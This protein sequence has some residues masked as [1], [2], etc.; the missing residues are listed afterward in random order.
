MINKKHGSWY[1]L[2]DQLNKF[3]GPAEKYFDGSWYWDVL[4]MDHRLYGYSIYNDDHLIY[5]YVNHKPLNHF[6]KGA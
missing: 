6:K 4:N 1:N 3:S 5:W 2:K